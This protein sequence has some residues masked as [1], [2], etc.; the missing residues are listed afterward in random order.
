MGIVL[1]RTGLGLVIVAFGVV[2]GSALGTAGYSTGDIIVKF[3]EGL[4]G[5][6]R[7]SI[8]DWYGCVI[9]ETCE[10]GR[11]HRVGIP[12][13]STPA[14]MVACL[15]AET[16]VEYAESNPYA[17]IFFEPNDPFYVYQWNLDN[18]V[19]GGIGL[20]MAWDLQQGD[21]NVIV[22]VLD[23]GVAFEDY[24]GFRVAP[25]LAETV[26]APGYDFVHDDNHPNDDQGHGTHVAGTIAQSTNNDRGVAGVAF[27]CTIM[28]VKVLGREG[29]GTHFAIARGVYF[30][31]ENGAR[32]INMSFGG[33][34]GSRTLRDAV[35]FAYRQGVTVVC[36]AG[37]DFLE[38][39]ARSFPAAYDDYCIAVG[40]V[41]YD[42]TRAYYSSTGLHLDL[43]APGGD[44]TVD[45]NRDG[46]PDGVLQQT[47]SLDP[48]DFN[49]FFFQ[50]TSMAA[51]HVSG[52]AAL[53]VSNGLTQPD[54]VRAAMEMT[55]RDAG[56][57]G[58]DTE[59]GWGIVDASAALR[60]QFVVVP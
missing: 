43:M 33:P 57:E 13:A 6:D 2:C 32:V 9:L 16:D 59:Y 52:V 31:V 34:Q 19:T 56:A 41:R 45:Q 18:D 14:Y 55:A 42:D 11:F 30:A 58:W 53:L 28:P 36:A 8:L 21:P 49:Y 47:F 15:R 48:T 60:Y 37:N 3:T 50:G 10:P 51:P 17:S 38:G 40:A 27:G 7:E 12:A 4:S 46:Y 35:A 24:E 20:R 26:F 44:L 54:E 25:D 29:E 22:A 23:T 5:P 39:N 1:K